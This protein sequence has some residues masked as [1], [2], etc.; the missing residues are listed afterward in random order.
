[1]PVIIF[2]TGSRQLNCATVYIL[3]HF[4]MLN[5]T[6]KSSVYVRKQDRPQFWLLGNRYDRNFDNGATQSGAYGDGFM[7][8]RL[9]HAV[10][11]FIGMNT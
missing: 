8:N 5:A 7:D 6:V 2:P 9:P 1:M 10:E 3:C 4:W 11:F